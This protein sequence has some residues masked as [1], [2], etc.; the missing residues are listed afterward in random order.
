MNRGS[1]GVVSV[2]RLYKAEIEYDG[3]DFAG[4][5]VQAKGERTVQGELENAI[6]RIAGEHS[7]VTGA[8]RTDSGVHAAGQVISFEAAWRHPIEDLHRALNAVLPP[9]ISVLG[10]TDLTT[11][12]PDFHPRF[13]ARRRHYRY[14]ILNA[15]WP[16]P[17]RRRYVYHVREPLSVP[18]MRRGGEHL[19]GEHDFA[20]FGSPPQGENTRRHVYGL[21]WQAEGEEVA[22]EICANAFLYRMVRNIAGTLVRVGL[23]EIPPEEVAEILESGDRAR[24]G[25]PAPPQGLCLT[26]IDYRV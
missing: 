25:P 22:F 6:A 21:T 4:F 5:Q 9:D 18:L 1:D 13:D 12:Q 15:R 8:G 2:K 7:R 20:A 19:V 26:R 11:T 17:L 10:L 23:G 14:T 24:G 3:S 16:S